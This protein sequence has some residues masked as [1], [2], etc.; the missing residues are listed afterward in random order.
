MT[1]TMTVG[2]VERSDR[3]GGLRKVLRLDR[4]EDLLGCGRRRRMVAARQPSSAARVRL[5]GSAS[6]TMARP[7]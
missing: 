2:R 1:E 4:K 3:R 7:A 5:S 6:T